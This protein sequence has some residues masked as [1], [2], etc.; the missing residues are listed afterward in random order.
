ML[1]KTMWSLEI[2]RF[3]YRTIAGSSLT[4]ASNSSVTTRSPNMKGQFETWIRLF[5]KW[6]VTLFV[7]I[8]YYPKEVIKKQSNQSKI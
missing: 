2:Y 6:K 8:L 4:V 7:T 3:L 5:A 1:R